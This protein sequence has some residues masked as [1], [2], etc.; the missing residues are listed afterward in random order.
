VILL[1]EL[2]EHDLKFIS[3]DVNT[4]FLF[5]FGLM[6][7]IFELLLRLPKTIQSKLTECI[8][9]FQH[10]ISKIPSHPQRQSFPF[11]QRELNIASVIGQYFLQ[12]LAYK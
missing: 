1:E 11:N 2:S 4:S 9:K 6:I 12:N 7:G 10:F 3:H 8:I 5:S